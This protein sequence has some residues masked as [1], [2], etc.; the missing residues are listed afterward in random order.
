M[1]RVAALLAGVAVLASGCGGSTARSAAE[2]APADVRAFVSLPV[3]HLDPLT[4]RALALTADGAR[5]QAILDRAG[6]VRAAHR[7][8][9]VAELADGRL[10]AFAQ[11]KDA[12][13]LGSFGLAHARARGW[14]IFAPTKD[15][16][17][18]A[19]AKRHLVDTRWYASAARAAGSS[20]ITFVAPGW[21]ALAAERGTVR[22]STRG[23]GTDSPTSDIP[24]DAIAA[25]G[26]QDGAALLRSAFA[27][28]VESALG[29][30]LGE[31]ASLVPG[32]AVIYVRPGVPIPGV[33]LLAQDGSLSAARR[34]VRAVAPDASAGV[35]ERVNG[36][37]LEHVNVGA[38]DLYY[39]RDGRMLVFSDDPDLSL[40]GP[41]ATPHD[42]PPATSAWLYVEAAK[43]RAALQLLARFEARSDVARMQREL[44]GLDSLLEHTTHEHGVETTTVALR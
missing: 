7:R 16:V 43:A 42:L 10:V 22:R 12:K 29:V 20:G 38:T 33:T 34:A 1:I 18:A 28:G 31:L 35:P 39:G 13:R 27:A 40:H 17:A 36:V 5:L 15:A 30:P 11:L 3:G 26:A 6:W 25:A 8:V 23:R 24:A 2:V 41:H 32:S 44:N 21:V 19:R 37:V 9:D 4:R 14:T